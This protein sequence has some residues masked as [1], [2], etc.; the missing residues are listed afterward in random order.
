MARKPNEGRSY[1][2]SESGG[3]AA[4]P[5]KRKTTTSQAKAAAAIQSAALAQQ[6]RNSAPAPTQNPVVPD[7][8]S[9]REE[10]QRLAYHLWEQRGGEGGSPEDDWLRAEQEYYSKKS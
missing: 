2:H 10:I 8:A 1:L 5:S 6:S 7:P 9:E 4:A 3:A